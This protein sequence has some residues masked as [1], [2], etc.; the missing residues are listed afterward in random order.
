MAQIQAV[1]NG[2]TSANLADE[3]AGNSG[4]FATNSRNA[5]GPSGLSRFS[6][7]VKVS[8]SRFVRPVVVP[9]NVTA[10]DRAAAEK[11][12]RETAAEFYGAAFVGLA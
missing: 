2:A 7:S 4:N 12:V 6:F 10:P 9:L 3:T 1:K 11:L 5:E 8:R